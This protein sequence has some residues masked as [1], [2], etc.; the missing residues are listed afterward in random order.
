MLFK[1][2]SINN[3]LLWY[4]RPWLSWCSMQCVFGLPEPVWMCDRSGN[5]LWLELHYSIIRY[6]VFCKQ[7][8]PYSWGKEVVPDA[9]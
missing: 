3:I 4:Y 8:G 5:M 7:P 2:G 6:D 9:E 1:C